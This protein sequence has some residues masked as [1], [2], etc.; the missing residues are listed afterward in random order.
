MLT[1]KDF[2]VPEVVLRHD[3]PKTSFEVPA[4]M[5][6]LEDLDEAGTEI[7]DP[8]AGADSEVFKA[9]PLQTR[10]LLFIRLP[11]R[12]RLPPMLRCELIWWPHMNDVG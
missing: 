8:E 1:C 5:C 10:L 7:Q 11:P 2:N 6:L 3:L 9:C 4:P 12:R